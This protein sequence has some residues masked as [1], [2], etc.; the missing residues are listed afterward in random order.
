[1]KSHD[2]KRLFH[3]IS[4]LQ[5]PFMILALFFM[6]KPYYDFFVNSD[7]NS[8]L[9]NANSALV[10]IGIGISF[11]TLQDT[12]KSQNK[13]SEKIWENPKKGKRALVFL[14]ILTLLVFIF[15]IF[16]YFM[17]NDGALKEISLGLIVLGIGLIGLLKTALEMFEN[18]VKY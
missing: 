9:A 15:G 10:F 12:V 5:Y 6:L 8:F 4:Y 14:S 1:M 17:S 18:H 7:V 2:I 11:S 3:I 16:G 13:F